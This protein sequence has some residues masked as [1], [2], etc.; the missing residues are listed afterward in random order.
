MNITPT[1]KKKNPEVPYIQTNANDRAQPPLPALTL[2][3]HLTEGTMRN[4]STKFENSTRAKV[5]CS[6][7]LALRPI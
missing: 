6:A 3:I 5:G 4:V 1:H 7:L 2:A